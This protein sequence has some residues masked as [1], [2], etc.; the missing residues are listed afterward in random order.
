MGVIDLEGKKYLSNNEVFADAFNYLIYKGKKII[1]ADKLI[2]QTNHRKIDRGTA[3]FLNAVAKLDLEYVEKK[4]G[5]DMCEAL[6]KRYK[7]KEI[8]GAVSVLK[9]LGKSDNEIIKSVMDTFKVTKKY[10]ISILNPKKA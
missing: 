9:A 6:E 7:E 1:K 2:I 4:G 8:N 5:I 10:V 3:F